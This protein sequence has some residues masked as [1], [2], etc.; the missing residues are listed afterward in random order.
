MKPTRQ[1]DAAMPAHH[2]LASP[3]RQEIIEILARGF[4]RYKLHQGKK[5]AFPLDFL[6]E[7]SDSCRVSDSAATIETSPAGEKNRCRY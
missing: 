2:H 6:R 1:P 7:K 5:L 4:L 3:A